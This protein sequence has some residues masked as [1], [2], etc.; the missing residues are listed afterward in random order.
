[1]IGIAKLSLFV[2]LFGQLGFSAAAYYLNVTN[3][4]WFFWFAIYAALAVYGLG[5]ITKLR[6]SVLDLYLFIC[7]GYVVLSFAFLGKSNGTEFTQR[8]L[9]FWIGPYVCGR[10]LGKYFSLSQLGILYGMTLFYISLV[11]VEFAANPALLLDTDRLLL[12]VVEGSDR[13][14]GDPTAFNLGVTLGAAWVAVVAS[15]LFQ[16]PKNSQSAPRSTVWLFIIATILPIVHMFVGSRGC[17]VAAV[18][19]SGFLLLNSPRLSTRNSISLLIGMV[20][21]VFVIYS[22]LPEERRVLVDQI[23]NAIVEFNLYV[24][25]S[26]SCILTGD[27]VLARMT[28]LSEM[29]RLFAESPFFGIGATN[30]GL[31]YCGMQAE[32]ASP[33]SL[34]AHVLVEF[35]LFGTLL[36]AIFFF[37]ILAAFFESSRYA[38]GPDYAA[39]WSLFALWL[40]FFLSFQFTGN[41]YYD[42]HM[43]LVTGLLVSRVNYSARLSAE[44]PKHT[45]R[46]LV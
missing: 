6:V 11:I 35:G 26:T 34:I 7:I 38:T 43:F 29:W 19:C 28:L 12:F 1:M 18:L 31:R 21:T 14:G 4:S 22:F 23:P 16:A 40:F 36:W 45:G 27:S 17:L 42:Y 44:A 37:G 32:F 46:V 20:S 39:M 13:T 5:N 30:F 9:L 33:H 25:D 3:P 2:V 15:L 10:F 8:I 24:A 41:L